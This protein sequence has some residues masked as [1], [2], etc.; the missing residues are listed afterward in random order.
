MDVNV[1]SR[2]EKGKCLLL[3]LGNNHL[4]RVIE[5]CTVCQWIKK[6]SSKSSFISIFSLLEDL[7]VAMCDLFEKGF[8]DVGLILGRTSDLDN[9]TWLVS[10]TKLAKKQL[11]ST[12]HSLERLFKSATYKSFTSIQTKRQSLI[13][14]EHHLHSLHLITPLGTIKAV[15]NG[16]S[17]VTER[18]RRQFHRIYLLEQLIYTFKYKK[19][20]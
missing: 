1:K 19:E 13:M 2:A 11:L 12:K 6:S 16:R 9:H 10:S 14:F 18:R 4:K 5:T 7:E 17:F 3:L 20:E 8:C 15:V